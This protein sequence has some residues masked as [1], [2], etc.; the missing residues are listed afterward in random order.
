MQQRRTQAMHALYYG[1]YFS[2][3]LDQS[4]SVSAIIGVC[5]FILNLQ[6]LG[7]DSP[8][9]WALGSV[10]QTS[11]YPPIAPPTQRLRSDADFQQQNFQYYPKNL[12]TANKFVPLSSQAAPANYNVAKTNV[13]SSVYSQPKNPQMYGSSKV[14]TPSNQEQQLPKYSMANVA[15]SP[16]KVFNS[17]AMGDWNKAGMAPNQHYKNNS[18]QGILSRPF[19]CKIQP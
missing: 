3:S 1:L 6:G 19:S 16:G 14:S 11:S 2:Y 18:V 4:S 9:I 13:P 7:L 8:S 12:L 17:Q 15:S 10:H 5:Y